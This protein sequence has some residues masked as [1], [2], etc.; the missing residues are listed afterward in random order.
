MGFGGARAPEVEGGPLTRSSTSSS[1]S[2]TLR[3]AMMRTA[4]LACFL[5]FVIVHLH[6][7]SPSLPCQTQPR[8]T[9]LY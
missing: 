4:Q 7:P 2:W 5:D 3:V 8:S 1:V 6:Y 9:G